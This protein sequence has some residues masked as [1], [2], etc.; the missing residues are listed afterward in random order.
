LRQAEATDE[1]EDTVNYSNIKRHVAEV[2]EK[3]SHRLLESLAA[4]ILDALFSDSRI[5][6]ARVRIS[7]PERLGGATPSVTLVRR[8]SNR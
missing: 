1:L 8:N 2:V 4:D 5:E 7:K 3:S 6:I